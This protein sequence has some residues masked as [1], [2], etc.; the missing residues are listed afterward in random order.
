MT[1]D[2]ARKILA[3]FARW[4][5]EPLVLLVVANGVRRGELLGHPCHDIDVG[6]RSVAIRHALEL[7]VGQ[8]I[9]ANP[10]REH[11]QRTLALP[12]P[13]VHAL[14]MR[15]VEEAEERLLGGDD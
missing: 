4:C 9:L 5:I 2:G 1:P 11:A 8:R 7:Y 14:E 12:R 10:K 3:A 13:A 6:R 15:C